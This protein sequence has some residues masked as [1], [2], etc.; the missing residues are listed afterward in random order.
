M[1]QAQ[2]YLPTAGRVLLALIFIV[3]GLGKIPAPE[4]TIGYMEAFGVP[5]V[6]FWPTVAVEVIG[7]IMLLVGFKARWA[8]AALA[9]FTLVAGLIFHSDFANQAEMTAFL[10]NLAIVGGMLYVIA[11]GAGALSLDRRKA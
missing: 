8:A 2:A 9:G 10:K 11:F 3:A 6:L 1:H 5:G 7:G 4:G